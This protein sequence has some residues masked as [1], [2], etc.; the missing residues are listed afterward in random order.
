MADAARSES[1]GAHSPSP[2]HEESGTAVG[3]IWQNQNGFPRQLV[4][5]K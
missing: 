4:L 1:F 3:R 2:C 5:F